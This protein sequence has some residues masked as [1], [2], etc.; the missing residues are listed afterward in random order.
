ME[1]ISFII[2]TLFFIAV[3]ALCIHGSLHIFQL[4]SYKP[5]VQR[6]WVAEHMMEVVKKCWWLVL[7]MPC[8]MNLGWVGKFLACIPCAIKSSTASS[9]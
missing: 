4:N 1:L 8:V 5:Y 6:K 7:V 2:L 9:N 3:W